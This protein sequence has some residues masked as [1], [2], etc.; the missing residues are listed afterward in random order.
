M[1]EDGAADILLPFL[2]RESNFL[3]TLKRRDFIFLELAKR[4]GKRMVYVLVALRK[5]VSWFGS[6][7]HW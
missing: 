4:Q 7:L 1:Y 3:I 6:R 5:V 2:T